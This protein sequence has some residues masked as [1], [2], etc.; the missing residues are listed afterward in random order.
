MRIRKEGRLINKVKKEKEKEMKKRRRLLGKPRRVW[1]P[2]LKHPFLEGENNKGS[3]DVRVSHGLMDL[4][5]VKRGLA[6][7]ITQALHPWPK[8]LQRSAWFEQKGNRCSKN[9]CLRVER[10]Q[11]ETMYWF[12]PSYNRPGAKATK[13][14]IGI[15]FQSSELQPS[16][17]F[18]FL[19]A[20]VLF[21]LIFV[22]FPSDWAELFRILP[23]GLSLAWKRKR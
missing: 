9:V 23:E 17:S 13:A 20:F 19:S 2:K 10:G 4:L 18:S 7:L 8:Q 12:P 15:G 14:S 22:V 1:G 21:S 16:S 5:G 3:K 11:R 6:P